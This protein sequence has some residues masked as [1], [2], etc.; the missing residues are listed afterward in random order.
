MLIIFI[1]SQISFSRSELRV[2]SKG[3]TTPSEVQRLP[4][5]D[6]LEIYMHDDYLTLEQRKRMSYAKTLRE[7]EGN[8]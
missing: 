7:K 3:D 1:N 2:E 8:S 4:N 6:V 5:E